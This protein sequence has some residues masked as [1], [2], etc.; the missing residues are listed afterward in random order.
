M[1]TIQTGYTPDGALGALYAGQN[2]ANSQSFND[3]DLAKLFIQNQLAQQ[4][5]QQNDQINPLDVIRKQNENAVGGYNAAL[6]NAKRTD[7]NYINMAI[8]GQNAQMQ[9]QMNSADAGKALVPYKIASEKSGL[10]NEKNKQDVMWTV[11][12]IDRQLAQ[13]GGDDG[14][15][16]IT[17]FNPMQKMFMQNKRAQL[18]DQLKTTAEF[19]GKKELNADKSAELLAAAEARANALMYSAD[20]RKPLPKVPAT[21]E[22]AMT[23]QIMGNQYMD[24]NE[25]HQLLQNIF[26]AK[27]Q[28]KNASGEDLA[29]IQTPEGKYKLAPRAVNAPV[30]GSLPTA[31][32]TGTSVPTPEA[33]QTQDSW[34]ATWSK[35]KTG[36]TMTG[37]DGKTYTKK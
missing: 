29:L 2:A 27:Q 26:N 16:N 9:N 30:T 37:L 33:P 15:G 24:D 4:T 28:N 5:Y 8:S 14:Q 34:N 31:S 12:D 6:A 35:L 11:G 32:Q 20:A 19:T 25:K 3:E 18:V 36:Q 7:P 13:G 17:P 22:A 10:E 23:Q 21:A 1:Q